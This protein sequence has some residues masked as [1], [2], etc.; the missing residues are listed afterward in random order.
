MKREIEAIAIATRWTMR[1]IVRLGTVLNE[2]KGGVMPLSG[3][4]CPLYDEIYDGWRRVT[5]K[6]FADGARE[7]IEV[8]WLRNVEGRGMLP[9][10]D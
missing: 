10:M 7:R 9:G 2:L 6:A 3:Y 5:R 4:D 1:R 8:L